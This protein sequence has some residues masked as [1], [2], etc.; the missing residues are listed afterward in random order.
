MKMEVRI[1]TSGIVHEFDYVVG[2][3]AIR[4]LPGK[5]TDLDVLGFCAQIYDC[6]LDGK[7]SGSAYTEAARQLAQCL[8]IKLL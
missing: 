8:K 7:M 4:I 3:E 2:K 5:V 6:G 1:G